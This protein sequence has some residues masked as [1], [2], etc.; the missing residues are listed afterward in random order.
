MM[1]ICTAYLPITDHWREFGARAEET[2]TSGNNHN[3]KQLVQLAVQLMEQL[4]GADQR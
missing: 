3:T 4:G 2:C 1:E